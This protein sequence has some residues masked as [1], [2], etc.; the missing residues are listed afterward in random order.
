[1]LGPWVNGDPM[2]KLAVVGALVGA[3]VVGTLSP[4]SEAEAVP[5]FPVQI[6]GSATLSGLGTLPYTVTLQANGT[7]TGSFGGIVATTGSWTWNSSL[8]RL[9]GIGSLERWQG[10]LSGGCF[11][12]PVEVPTLG[13][14]GTWTGCVVP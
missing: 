1:M 11:S 9:R 5:S 10:F 14:T 7:Y 4:I 13:S 8:Q 3:L 12:G 2:N 6:N